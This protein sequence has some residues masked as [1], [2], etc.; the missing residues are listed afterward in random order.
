MLRD[1]NLNLR[2]LTSVLLV[3]GLFGMAVVS[4]VGAAPM[5]NLAQDNGTVT[6]PTDTPI[7]PTITLTP[8]Q[9]NTPTDTPTLTLTPT[10]T[11]T[12][13]NTMTSTTTPTLTSTPTITGTSTDIPTLTNT[14]TAPNHIVIS[15]FR[16]LGPLGADDELVELFNPT[17]AAVNIGGWLIRKSSACGTSLQTL[18]TI[19]SGTILQPGQHYLLAASGSNSSITNADQT[20]SPGIADDGGLALVNSGLTIDQ[21]GMCTD[22][23]YREGNV[24]QPLSGTSN[25]SYDRKPGGDTACYDTNNNASDFVRSAANPH[26][27]DSQ[28]VMC[29][30]VILSSPTHTP[31]RTLTGTP[32]RGPTAIPAEVVLN[33]F[34]PHPRSDWNGDGTTN[35]GDEYIEIINL[36]PIAIN[37]KNW[38]LD[39]GTGSSKTF[40]LPDITLQPRQIAA[41]FGSQTGLSLSD[42]GAT[43]RLLKPDGYIED[44]F[45][46]PVV[47]L[48]DWTWCRLPDGT[49]VWGFACRPSPDRPN[50]FL[51]T[52]TPDSLSGN[53]SICL[54][55]KTIPQSQIPVECGHFDSGIANNPGEKLFWLQSRWKWDVFVE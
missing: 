8:T 30:G 27:Q 23:Y 32:T 53:S 7:T 9:T 33:E 3:G 4:R 28:A 31:T 49:G 44:A 40:S 26:N 39:T 42:G 18:V 11:D 20:F 37:V 24:L 52:P 10:H 22:T 15:Q 35:V 13:T 41:F 43:V 48:A 2:V 46:Y 1:K 45:T 12:P 16:T 6:L 38:K 25:Q 51:N 29:A 21:V 50:I 47:E 36:G 14:P 17:G 55:E 54:L 5:K 19:S 34:L